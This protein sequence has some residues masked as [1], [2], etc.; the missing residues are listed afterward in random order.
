MR[1]RRLSNPKGSLKCQQLLKVLMPPTVQL[2]KQRR[3]QLCRHLAKFLKEVER[4]H[5]HQ[6]ELA[7]RFPEHI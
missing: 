3:E 7:A 6:R 5:K 1:D 2:M 4:K